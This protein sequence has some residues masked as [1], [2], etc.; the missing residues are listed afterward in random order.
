MSEHSEESLAGQVEEAWQEMVERKKERQLRQDA[1][2]AA[3]Q[4]LEH[5]AQ[6]LPIVQWLNSLDGGDMCD[7]LNLQTLVRAVGLLQQGQEMADRLYQ[8]VVVLEQESD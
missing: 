6:T 2:K 7:M 8:A 1:A 4:Q 3:I 5:S